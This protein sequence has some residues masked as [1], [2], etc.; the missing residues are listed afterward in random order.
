M[1]VAG[2]DLGVL[3]TNLGGARGP[4]GQAGTRIDRHSVWMRPETEG[5]RVSLGILGFDRVDPRYVDDRRPL[6]LG[7]DRRRGV[8]L[9]DVDRE[10]LEIDASLAVLDA[11][12]H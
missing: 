2:G 10:R 7:R 12:G 9:R 8:G 1:V 5:D 3:T 4:G 11:E 6:G